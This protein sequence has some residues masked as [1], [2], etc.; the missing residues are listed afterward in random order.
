M[1]RPSHL[2]GDADK[3]GH[4]Q[5]RQ[6][7]TTDDA[8]QLATLGHQQELKRNFNFISMLGLAFSILVS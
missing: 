2:G 4:A 1:E 8:A 6:T 3:D 7:S 5:P